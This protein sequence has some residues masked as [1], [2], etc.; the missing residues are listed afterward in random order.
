[1]R[2]SLE[3]DF[4]NIIVQSLSV[5]ATHFRNDSLTE[6]RL[7]VRQIRRQIKPDVALLRRASERP[8]RYN[9]RSGAITLSGIADDDNSTFQTVRRIRPTACQATVPSLLVMAEPAWNDDAYNP[10]IVCGPTVPA[11]LPSPPRSEQCRVRR[12]SHSPHSLPYA[13]PAGRPSEHG[14]HSGIMLEG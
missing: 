5:G 7:C 3:I 13:G 6:P 10:I 12:H 11:A 1:M 9:R 14:A 2:L 8:L 4:P